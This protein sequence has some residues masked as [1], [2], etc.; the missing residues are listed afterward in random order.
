[1]INNSFKKIL[2]L[3]LLLLKLK[4]T[5][6]IKIINLVTGIITEKKVLIISISLLILIKSFNNIKIV[7][8]HL[9]KKLIS[10]IMI[11]YPF[12]N[13]WYKIIYP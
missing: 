1:M 6:K 4:I 2:K 10:S 13:R 5:K 9:I 12:L 11:Q 8:N 7:I 3:L